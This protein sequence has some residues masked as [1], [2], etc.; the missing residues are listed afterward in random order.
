MT[1]VRMS[2]GGTHRRHRGHRRRHRRGHRA[3][4]Y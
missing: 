2:G 3:W 4:R 1:D